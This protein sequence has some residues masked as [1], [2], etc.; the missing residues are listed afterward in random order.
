MNN[1]CLDNI[2]VVL[3]ETSSV[4]R[5]VDAAKIT[6]GLGFKNFVVIKAYGVAA[7]NGIPE[8]TKI[9]LKR[10][11]NFHVLSKIDDL[12]EILG[13]DNLIFISSD[14]GEKIDEN[15]I[16]KLGL[17]EK[18]TAIIIGGSE[19]AITRQDIAKGIAVYPSIAETVIGPLGELALILFMAKKSGKITSDNSSNSLG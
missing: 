9:A 16:G 19:T 18:K 13:V 14:Y 17:C 15:S 1:H 3:Y 11:K 4:Q 6:Y 7:Q 5:L 12:V 8:A 2:I 10:G